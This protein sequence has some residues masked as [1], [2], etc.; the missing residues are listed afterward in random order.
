MLP[1]RSLF[2]AADDTRQEN[3]TFTTV[4]VTVA[5]VLVTALG[6]AT[7]AQARNVH[8]QA[9]TQTQ[10]DFMAQVGPWAETC[11]EDLMAGLSTGA[12]HDIDYFWA[13]VATQV[14]TAAGTSANDFWSRPIPQVHTSAGTQSQDDFWSLATTRVGN[15]GENPHCV[16]SQPTTQ[17]GCDA[18]TQTQGLMLN[19]PAACVLE[20][21]LY[22]LLEA[23]QRGADA[24][25]A[26]DHLWRTLAIAFGTRH[27]QYRRG[28]YVGSAT[29]HALLWEA[30][31]LLF[32]RELAFLPIIWSEIDHI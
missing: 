19:A 14:S 10:D 15:Q 17:V 12:G 6:S 2:E 32:S 27:A 26:T 7:T 16:W 13:R 9:G 5:L 23:R 20:G 24:A 18:G 3:T 21:A 4:A 11:A 30:M 28:V 8:N 25:T 22:R 29:L 31:P 1:I